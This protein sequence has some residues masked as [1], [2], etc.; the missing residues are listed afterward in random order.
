M[1]KLGKGVKHA[2]IGMSIKNTVPAS[3]SV[4]ASI[5]PYFASFVNTAHARFN[6]QVHRR[7]IIEVYE[8]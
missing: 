5:A 1:Q 6:L 4:I 7:D 2:R 8:L 3:H